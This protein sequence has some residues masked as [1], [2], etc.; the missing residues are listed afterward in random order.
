[1]RR[2]LLT[3][4]RREGLLMRKPPK[5]ERRPGKLLERLRKGSG[6]LK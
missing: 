3:K 1:M 6:S 5:Q 4:L 2:G